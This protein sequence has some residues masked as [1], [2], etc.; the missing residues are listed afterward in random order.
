MAASEK[1]KVNS[2]KARANSERE[3]AR[4]RALLSKHGILEE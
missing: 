2:E 3:I 1:E 4:L